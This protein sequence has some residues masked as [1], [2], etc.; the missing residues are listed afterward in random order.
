MDDDKTF[1]HGCLHLAFYLASFG[2]LR[3]GLFLL[4][5]DYR[6]HEYFLNDVVRNPQFHKYFDKEFQRNISKV[7]VKG[8]DSLIHKTTNAYIKNKSQINGKDSEQCLVLFAFYISVLFKT[9]LQEW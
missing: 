3:W 1:D 7:S 4:Q 2:I 9:L 5:K 8:I 6:I